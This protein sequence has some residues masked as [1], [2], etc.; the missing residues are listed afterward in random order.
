MSAL[1]RGCRN[2][3]RIDLEEVVQITDSSVS[4]LVSH[5]TRLSTLTLSHC[6]LITNEGIRA[7]STCAQYLKLLELDNCPNLT[8][9]ALDHLANLKSLERLEIYDCQHI[10]RM[11]IRRIRNALPSLMIHAYFAPVT[12]PLVPGDQGL[13]GD[14]VAGPAARRTICR[15]CIIL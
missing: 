4:V 5:C 9:D 10:S 12:P 2:L 11:G 1:A 7:I 6:E 14:G 15:C 13:P 3:T 8:D